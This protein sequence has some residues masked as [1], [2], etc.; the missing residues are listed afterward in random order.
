MTPEAYKIHGI[1]LEKYV[2]SPSEAIALWTFK[3]ALDSLPQPVV[4]SGYNS[5][6]YDYPLMQRCYPAAAF[7]KYPKLD[8]MHLAMRRD[9]GQSYK[10]VD[11]FDQEAEE[12]EKG[13]ARPST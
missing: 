2:L 9:E 3:T 4:L 6:R 8:V 13:A 1:G 11:V 7:D 5:D 10:L 12:G